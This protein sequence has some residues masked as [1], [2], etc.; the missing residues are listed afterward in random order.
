MKGRSVGLCGKI[1]CF[2]LVFC[3]WFVSG[4][5]VF[6]S[7]DAGIITKALRSGTISNIT[8]SSGSV[9]SITIEWTDTAFSSDSIYT[10]SGNTYYDGQSTGIFN[11]KVTGEEKYTFEDLSC[12]TYINVKVTSSASSKNYGYYEG[13]KTLP[14]KVADVDYKFGNGNGGSIYWTYA[15]EGSYAVRD[16]YE[17]IIKNT[18]GKKLKTKR[19]SSEPDTEGVSFSKSVL[20][21]KCYKVS[22]RAYIL[23]ADDE[24]I[25]GKTRTFYMVPQPV[26]L[27]GDGFVKKN[28]AY[29]AWESVDGAESYSIYVARSSSYTTKISSLK[30]K[31]ITVTDGDSC[32]ITKYGGKTINTS[33]YYY[34]FYIVTNAKI[35]SKTVKSNVGYAGVLHKGL[36]L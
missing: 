4:R 19:Y 3:L 27:S 8:Q 11:I 30:F 2:T 20:K 13:A 18:S 25:Y 15:D 16:G 21:Q 34:Y 28:R 35:N 6:A 5:C 22:I 36:S 12:G 33:K 7:E 10:L 23:N 29:L 9:T 32:V 26:W 24:R 17:V 14:G 1:L 31:K